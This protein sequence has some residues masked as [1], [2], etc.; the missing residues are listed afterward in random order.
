MAA[1]GHHVESVRGNE[2]LKWSI[3]GAPA[4]AVIALAYIFV[5]VYK[6]WPD[7][8]ARCLDILQRSIPAQIPSQGRRLVSGISTSRRWHSSSRQLSQTY[9]GKSYMISGTFC[10][11]MT[12]H[13][14][15]IY[16]ETARESLEEIDVLFDEDIPAWRSFKA[17]TF[18]DRVAEVRRTGGIAELKNG[19]ST[20]NEVA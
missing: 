6:S 9:S 16:P 14:F 10:V 11:V 5:G 13:A 4:K 18:V 7:L 20:H 1:Y 17:G 15:F 8:G 19:E 3:E 2:I 12:V